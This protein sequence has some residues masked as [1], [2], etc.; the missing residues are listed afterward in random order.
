[1]Q[2]PEYSGWPGKLMRYCYL[3]F[4]SMSLRSCHVLRNRIRKI[5]DN[6]NTEFEKHWQCLEKNNQ[7][8]PHIPP[9]L[10]LPLLISLAL[11][12][13]YFQACRTDETALNS[14]L[15]DKLVSGCSR[16]VTIALRSLSTSCFSRA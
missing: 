3:S 14:C 9:P 11:P 8:R 12:I 6:C 5:R 15:L 7:V 4:P 16:L 10:L 2:S 13:Q 1:M